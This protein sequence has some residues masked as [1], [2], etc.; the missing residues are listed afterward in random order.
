M[1]KHWL[2]HPPRAIKDW[3]GI[4]LCC[5]AFWAVISRL[6]LLLAAFGTVWRLA[7]PFV[8]GA[9]LAYVLDTLVRPLH[10][11]LLHSHPR[12][13]WAAILVAY[14]LAGL[15]L[16]GLV[17]LVL[18]QL[19]R[20]VTALFLNLPDWIN[21]MQAGLVDLQARTNL[22]FRPLITALDDYEQLMTGLW[23]LLRSYTPQLV[24]SLGS[25]AS[26]TVQIVIAVAASV[27]ML[28]DKDHLQRQM[29][30]LVRAF[31]PRRASDWLLNLARFANETFAS[32]FF[33]KIIASALI[34][35]LLCGLMSLL[36]IH[37]APLISV[38]VAFGNLIPFVGI[39][40]GALPGVLI[41]LFVSPVQALLCAGLV[42][43]L[44][45]FDLRLLAPRLLGHASGLSAFWVLVAIVAGGWLYGP[46]G[47]VLGVPTFATLYALARRFVYWLLARRSAADAG[48]EAGE[49]EERETVGAGQG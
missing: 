29:R 46:I 41:L 47:M 20:S 14:L 5:I 21:K 44:Q 19:V 17:R 9:V 28:A 33:G 37:F 36:R 31:L 27:F 34:G 13:R 1:G 18:P 25:V 39:W 40:I 32:F 24:S 42:A 6:D 3:L 11:W 22:D 10:R 2:D 35:V 43:L 15:A 23:E 7:E 16:F 48:E 30:M 4:A 12:L 38:L 8:W 26:Y 45:Q 49:E